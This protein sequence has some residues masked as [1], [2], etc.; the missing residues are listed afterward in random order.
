VRILTTRLSTVLLVL[1]LVGINLPAY[2]QNDDAKT[3]TGPRG[4][5]VAPST[6]PSQAGSASTLKSPPGMEKSGTPV[7]PSTDT[8]TA[9]S[10]Q[11]KAKGK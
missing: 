10:D 6:N 11:T 7:S 2:S 8:A 9:K 3:G 5:P 1:A 4:T